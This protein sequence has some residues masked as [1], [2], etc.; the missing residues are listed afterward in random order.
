MKKEEEK[1]SK[2][3]GQCENHSYKLYMLSENV[4]D[5]FEKCNGFWILFASIKIIGC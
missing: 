4:S 1:T 3:F 5:K 2:H